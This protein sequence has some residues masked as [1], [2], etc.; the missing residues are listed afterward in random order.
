MPARTS[1]D[2]PRLSLDARRQLLLVACT[3][4]RVNLLAKFKSPPRAAVLG[5]PHQLAPWMETAATVAARFLPP[6]L[7]LLTTLLQAIR[8]R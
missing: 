4:D 3:I 5:L 7:R 2:R 6:K 1:G 8:R